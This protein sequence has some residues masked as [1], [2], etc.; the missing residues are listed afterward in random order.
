LL[1]EVIA[2]GALII[3]GSIMLVVLAEGGRRWAERRL[4]GQ[5][6]GSGA[7]APDSEQPPATFAIQNG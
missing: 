3:A 5:T 7:V 1:P 2:V 6:A 4:V